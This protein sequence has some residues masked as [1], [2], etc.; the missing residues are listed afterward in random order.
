MNQIHMGGGKEWVNYSFFQS[1]VCFP[2]EQD[3]TLPHPC[4]LTAHGSLLLSLSLSLCV[5]ACACAPASVR[6][7]VCVCVC[8]CVSE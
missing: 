8:V 3:G 7:C 4:V 5:R 1:P 2:M 6:V